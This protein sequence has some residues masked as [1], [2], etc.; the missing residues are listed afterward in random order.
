MFICIIHLF[1]QTVEELEGRKAHD[2]ATEVYMSSLEQ[3]ETPEEVSFN[4]Y[5]IQQ[6][7]RDSSKPNF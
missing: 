2:K 7:L 5:N 6:S 3:S 4:S 1:L